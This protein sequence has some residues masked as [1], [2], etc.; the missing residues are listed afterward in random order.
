MTWMIPRLKIMGA[1]TAECIPSRPSHLWRRWESMKDEEIG[2]E[3]EQ[4]E[5]L[6]GVKVVASPPQVLPEIERRL[7]ILEDL[8]RRQSLRNLMPD[9]ESSKTLSSDRTAEPQEREDKDEDGRETPNQRRARLKDRKYAAPNFSQSMI[10]MHRITSKGVEKAVEMKVR[11]NDIDSQRRFYSLLAACSGIFGTFLAIIQNELIYRWHPKSGKIDILKALNSFSSFVCAVWIFYMYRMQLRLVAMNRRLR[12]KSSKNTK[13]KEVGFL[14]VLASRG[15]WLE[16]LICVPHLPPFFSPE[17]GMEVQ[18]GNFIL[19]RGETI[20]C[21]YNILR[22]YLLWRC[23]RD[24]IIKTMPKHFT[25]EA[26]TQINIGSFYVLKSLLEGWKGF[27]F[28]TFAWMF[29]MLVLGYFFRAFETSACLFPFHDHPSCF[30]PEA[31]LWQ[32][33]SGSL[34][35]ESILVRYSDALWAMFIT[36][37]SVG[38]GDIYAVTLLGRMTSILMAFLG[39]MFASLMTASI[40]NAFQWNPEEARTLAIFE[41]E[42]A[43]RHMSLTAMIHMKDKMYVDIET[44]GSDNNKVDIIFSRVKN[45]QGMLETIEEEATV[46]KVPLVRRLSMNSIG[47]RD[48]NQLSKDGQTFPSMQGSKRSGSFKMRVK[49]AMTQRDGTGKWHHNFKALHGAQQSYRQWAALLGMTGT[50]FAVAQ[51]EYLMQGGGQSDVTMNALKAMNSICTLSCAAFILRMYYIARLLEAVSLHVHCFTDL[52]TDV[53]VWW[54]LDPSLWLELVLVLVHNPPSYRF[55]LVTD[56]LGENNI[57]VTCGETI[58][59]GCNLIRIYLCW[60]VLRDWILSVFPKHQ[61]LSGFQRTKIGSSFA[62]KHIMHSWYAAIYMSLVWMI[63][64]VLLGKC[65]GS[66]ASRDAAAAYWFRAAETT[67]CTLPHIREE[68]PACAN[69]NAMHWVIHGMDFNKSSHMRMTTAIWFILITSTTVGYGLALLLLII[70]IIITSFRAAAAAEVSSQIGLVAASLLTA[71][72]TNL[73]QFSSS[74]TTAKA[75]IEREILRNHLQEKSAQLL[76]LFW[77]RRKGKT[78]RKDKFQNIRLIGHDIRT[79]KIQTTSD[80]EV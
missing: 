48:I 70:I 20:F 10:E 69:P 14:Q 21:V 61:T 67:A 25:I 63:A 3:I 16:L 4:V 17:F 49:K 23:I 40:S 39:L 64:I 59:C 29:S 58:L 50:L 12:V 30:L 34:E 68:V 26:F 73:L 35:K 51:N 54:L 24:F 2:L 18:N 31:V 66:D 36:S 38:Y 22:I 42:R 5:T 9:M 75:L 41:R 43:R 1:A 45:L 19:Y 8:V 78:R 62:I 74:E 53:G 47:R 32:I 27:Q 79:M 37:T 15:L 60:R 46:A 65:S 72:L 55:V 52:I 71:A 57:Y 7:S 80:I 33:D 44:S 13:I 28:V 6:F 77:R 76:Q 56:N 11:R